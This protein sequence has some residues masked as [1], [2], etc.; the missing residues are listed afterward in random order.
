MEANG[1]PLPGCEVRVVD[2]ATGSDQPVAVPGEILA[3]SY[4][5][6]QGYYKKPE[7][8]ARGPRR[9][10]L[11][12]HGRHGRSCAPTATCGSSAATRTC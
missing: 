1:Y 9:G 6:T 8:T 11:V 7:E 5:V 10:R 3:R 12:S 2:P 4:M